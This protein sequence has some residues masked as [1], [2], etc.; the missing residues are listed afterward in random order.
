MWDPGDTFESSG[1]DPDGVMRAYGM[2][3]FRM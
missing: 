2:A 1:F 3:R